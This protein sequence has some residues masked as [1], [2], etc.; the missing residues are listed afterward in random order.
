MAG[1]NCGS[2]I[3][4]VFD[5]DGTLTPSRGLIDP[6]FKSFFLDFIKHHDVHI[7]T[8]GSYEHTVQQLGEDIAHGVEMVFNCSGNVIT[9][10]GQRLYEST[11]TLPNDLYEYLAN[12]LERSPYPTK[13]G[14]HF[15]ERCGMVNF[16]VVGRNTV[17]SQRSDYYQWDCV[18]RER[19]TLAE[20][21]NKFWPEVEAVEGGETGIDIFKR[22]CD[23]SQIIK[24]LTGDIYFYGDRIDPLGNDWNIAQNIIAS[25]RGLCYNVKSWKDTFNLLKAIH[26]N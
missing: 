16:S 5:V 12:Y 1:S 26:T 6:E 11:W 3:N 20:Y 21:I 19:T 4:Y 14:K 25:D 13:T 9:S 22:G 24:H 17:G 15:D 7:V 2:K 18:N 8:G 10:K 23:K